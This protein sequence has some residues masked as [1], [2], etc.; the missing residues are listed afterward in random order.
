MKTL[1]VIPVYNEE[2]CLGNVLRRTLEMGID[3]LVVDDGSSDG[4]ADV[5]KSFP[6]V[7]VIRHSPNKG[8]G[9]A[10]KSGFEYGCKLGYDCVITMDSDGQHEPSL[11]PEFIEAAADC[12]IVSGSRYLK[13]FNENTP[14]PIE[15]RRINSLVTDSLNACFELGLTDAFCGFK[16][17]RTAALEQ[18]DLRETG[19]GMPLELW[20][21]A[22]CLKLRIR[23][24][25]V[26]CVYLD[27]NRSFGESLDDG[28]RRLAYYQRV[29][30]TAIAR[31]RR[32]DDCGLENRHDPVFQFER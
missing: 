13:I 15:R 3:L 1:I 31:T 14:A 8:Y 21:Q 2:S 22:A 16:A 27:P 7:A 24:I 9:A 12:D 28:N 30:D 17:Y 5:L 19:Y 10:L 25:A 18:L 4:T 29:I 11:I 6:E 20:V 32:R 26:P 23:E